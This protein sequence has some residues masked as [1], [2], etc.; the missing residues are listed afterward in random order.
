M[1]ISSICFEFCGDIECFTS[2]QFSFITS[3]FII[4]HLGALPKSRH[5]SCCSAEC[6]NVWEVLVEMQC[7]VWLDTAPS[8]KYVWNHIHMRP[9]RLRLEQHDSR[10][11]SQFVVCHDHTPWVTTIPPESPPMGHWKYQFQIETNI[12]ATTIPPSCC[13]YHSSKQIFNTEAYTGITDVHHIIIDSSTRG[14]INHRQKPS[15]S[16]KED[17]DM[18]LSVII[19]TQVLIILLETPFY[20]IAVLILTSYR[21]KNFEWRTTME[22]TIPY[23]CFVGIV[24]VTI[25]MFVPQIV[26]IALS[27]SQLYARHPFVAWEI[28]SNRRK[29][30][31]RTQGHL[32][33]N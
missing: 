16:I 6:D 5:N 19:V 27:D 7:I 17:P 24:V 31:K 15:P 25:L 18:P 28:G 11:L 13:T 29:H 21:I 12:L 32:V 3:P 20:F 30:T 10:Y 2:S 9:M 23:E 4:I 14:P 8:S 22:H 26:F 1:V 33:P